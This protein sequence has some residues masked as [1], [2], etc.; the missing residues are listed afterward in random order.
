MAFLVPL[1]TFWTPWTIFVPLMFP[2]SSLKTCIN[3]HTRLLNPLSRIYAGL[4]CK[5]AYIRM[6]GKG[7]ILL[8]SSL[9]W[10]WLTS[11]LA[12]HM[13]WDRSDSTF[14]YPMWSYIRNHLVHWRGK[15]RR[16]NWE[17]RNYSPLLPELYLSLHPFVPLEHC[18][19]LPKLSLVSELAIG[20]MEDW[21]GGGPSGGF[22]FSGS[23]MCHRRLMLVV[24]TCCWGSNISIQA[25]DWK[26]QR[27]S[28]STVWNKVRG[29]IL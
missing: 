10:I 26:A 11:L 19:V 14:H 2:R 28:T 1:W 22:S 17:Y 6:C 5:T 27:G 12:F 16:D 25:E 15:N 4:T 20:V 21:D 29:L 9:M 23:Q 13:P 24:F 3:F 18:C 7:Q 8:E